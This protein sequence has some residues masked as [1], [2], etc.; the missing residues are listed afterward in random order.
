MTER[1]GKSTGELQKWYLREWRKHRGLTQEQLAEAID[2]TKPTVSRMENGTRPY[3]QPF[4]EACAEA[5]HCTPAQLLSGSPNDGD[6]AK[7]II[8]LL[9]DKNPEEIEK[10]Y[11]MISLMTT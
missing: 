8:A 9:K 2:S 1:F 7:Y 3:N 4:L 5:L 6:K 11:K 10:I